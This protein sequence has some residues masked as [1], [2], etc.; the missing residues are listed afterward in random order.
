MSGFYSLIFS[1]VQGRPTL[2]GLILTILK[3]KFSIIFLHFISLIPEDVI[4]R[5]ILHPTYIK[6]YIWTLKKDWK[7]VFDILIK[8]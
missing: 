7:K 8:P 1:K 2:S 6:V 3:S 5:V 4:Y